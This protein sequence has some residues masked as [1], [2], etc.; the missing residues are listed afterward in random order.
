MLLT[1]VATGCAPVEIPPAPPITVEV[2][3]PN[4]APPLNQEAELN[5]VI[6]SHWNLENMSVEIR[7]PE[8]LELVS[9]ELSWFGDVAEGD[10]I[11]AIEVMVRAV[12][13]GNWA[14]EL[15]E[16]IDPEEQGGFGFVPGWRE[17]IYVS[18]FEDS[19]EWA[20]YPPWYEGGNPVPIERVDD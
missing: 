15:D 19:A 7:L 6:K 1:S 8:G 4:G 14:I 11:V 3:F 12:K 13:I 18:I 9:G 2:S 16:S 5:R 10:E 20:I 17:A